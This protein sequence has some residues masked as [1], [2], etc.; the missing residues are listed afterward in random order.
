MDDSTESSIVDP[1]RDLFRKIY[2]QN[3]RQHRISSSLQNQESYFLLLQHSTRLELRIQQHSQNQSAK[4]ALNDERLYRHAGVLT[5]WEV[6]SRDLQAGSLWLQHALEQLL[7]ACPQ[8]STIIWCSTIPRQKPWIQGLKHGRNLTVIDSLLSDPWGWD[9]DDSS[10]QE[11]SLNLLEKITEEIYQKST[12][13]NPVAGIVLESL[14]PLIQRHGFANVQSFLHKLQHQSSKG[15]GAAPILLVPIL[16]EIIPSAQ[17]RT[18][19]DM[20]QSVLC[21]DQGEATWLRQGVRERGNLVHQKLPYEIIYSRKQNQKRINIITTDQQAS[22]NLPPQNA[23]ESDGMKGSSTELESGIASLSLISDE[24]TTMSKSNSQSESSALQ[25]STSTTT[26]GRA[27]VQLAF[28]D[29]GRHTTSQRDEDVAPAPAPAPRIF[30]EEDDPEFED[31]DEE[32]PDD[33]LDL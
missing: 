33:D 26:R 15:T 29:E 25:E 5:P 14:T 4:G 16:T 8:Q 28:S 19:E 31:Y 1:L 18:L 21:L 9:G 23:D 32:D 30:M 22:K 7:L 27:K 6:A 11:G 10:H 20:A 2:Q 24:L 13:E 17:H 12:K 3:E